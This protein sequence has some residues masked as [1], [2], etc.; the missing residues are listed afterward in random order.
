M[1]EFYT[2]AIL[3]T[4]KLDEIGEKQ[5][6]VF[7]S[8]GGQ[9]GPLMHVPLCS[10]LF[11]RLFLNIIYSWTVLTV[12]LNCSY[13]CSLSFQRHFM[14]MCSWTVPRCVLDYFKDLTWT[15][16][17]LELFLNVFLVILTTNLEHN[18]F[19]NCS[20]MCSWLFQ[21]NVFLNCS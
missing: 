17:V 18:V 5:L 7:G 12:F 3:L 19:M 1:S 9:S 4:N 15:R 16:C 10:W 21:H 11:R 2:W 8:R 6:S 14:N 13:M 20:Y